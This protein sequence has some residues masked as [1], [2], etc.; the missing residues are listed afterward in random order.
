MNMRL[1]QAASVL[2]RTEVRYLMAAGGVSVLSWA[3]VAL[4]LRL[5]WHYMLATVFS[6][7]AP[8]PVAFPLYRRFVFHSTG[9][10]RGDLL[11][12][13]VVWGSG[14]IAPI[15]AAPLFVEGLR[16]NPVLAQVVITVVVAI[17]S[18]LGH[19]F[20]SFRRAATRTPTTTRRG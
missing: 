19:R 16:M 4:G 20:F 18:F 1:D 9:S 17:G 3:M 14:M 7:V 11:R 6:Q 10:L 2:R 8:I 15:A 5:G 12:F 13:M